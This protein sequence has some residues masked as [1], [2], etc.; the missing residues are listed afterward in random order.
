MSNPNPK[1][2]LKNT[3]DPAGVFDK[4]KKAPAAPQPKAADPAQQAPTIDYAA[5]QADQN[6][7]RL[8]R[9]RGVMANIFAGRQTLG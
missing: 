2:L 4:K 8:R 9:R 5:Q 3:L 6:M 1:K 7:Q